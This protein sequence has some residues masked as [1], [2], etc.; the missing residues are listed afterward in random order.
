MISKSKATREPSHSGLKI[1]FLAVCSY[2]LIELIDFIRAE[3]P[4]TDH[5][6]IIL[7][8]IDTLRYDH[9]GLY[10]YEFPTTPNLDE[11]AK[12][13]FVFSNAISQAPSTLQ[14]HASLL[15]SQIPI[16]HG[17]SWKRKTVIRDSSITLAEAL[18]SQNYRTIGFHGGGQMSPTFGLGRGFESY[19]L[20]G[21]QDFSTTV[22]AA[23]SWI[24][25]E[26]RVTG[27]EKAL[28]KKPFFL[29]M[30]NY[31]VHHPYTPKPKHIKALRA[32]SSS[33]LP[34]DIS[35]DFIKQVNGVI[36]PKLELV[37]G[38]LEHIIR[39]YDAEIRG[40]DEA[41]GDLVHFLKN[42]GI[43]DRTIIVFTSDHGEEFNE[44]GFVGWHG[45]TLFDE[46]LRV[47]LLIKPA[48]G[49]FIKPATA[50]IV[51]MR[52]DR[53]VRSIDI[54]PTILEMAGLIAPD[55]VEGTSLNPLLQGKP[56]KE[57]DLP[58]ISQRD[59]GGDTIDTAV[60]T[61]SWKYIRWSGAWDSS[62][63]PKKDSVLQHLLFDLQDDPGEQHDLSKSKS[64]I[65]SSLREI[66]DEFNQHTTPPDQME[67][68]KEVEAQLRAL[69]YIRD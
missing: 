54:M 15:T 57:E 47:P 6:N 20:W 27:K 55:S 58:T 18:Q 14:S 44:R 41:F 62:Y 11:F 2:G 32:P 28:K 68:S 43:Y 60:R 29:F 4:L 38:D 31:H 3:A 66:S 36:S 63:P 24:Q 53:P 50:T 9:L 45:H 67:L 33:S 7:I 17:A 10:G 34:I 23:K 65:F 1:L 46:L 12:D 22:E 56:L 49:D 52:I 64:E 26:H 13:A 16:R 51:E 59:Q 25:Y 35:V 42:Q 19:K 8:S 21:A 61:A 37:P 5:P 69:G 30:H 39:S 40:M 48:T